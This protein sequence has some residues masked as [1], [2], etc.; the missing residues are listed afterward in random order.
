MLKQSIRKTAIA[1]V[2]GLAM[3]FA[4]ALAAPDTAHAGK[5]GKVAAAIIGGLVVGAI[6]GS[7]SRP[8]YSHSY[9]ANHRAYYGHRPAYHGHHYA[10][11][12]RCHWRKRQVWDP[13]GGFYRWQKV[14][15]CH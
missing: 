3:V 8:A 1:G 14:R 12:Q 9:G 2:A 4:G 13:Y 10:P 7:Q 11:R 6:I 15:V 5:N